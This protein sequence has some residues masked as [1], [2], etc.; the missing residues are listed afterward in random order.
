MGI[1]TP[2]INNDDAMLF[3]DNQRI[4]HYYKSRLCS[5]AL[6]QFIWDWGDIETT[7]RLFFEKKLLFEGKACLIKPEGS[8]MWLSLGYDSDGT[9]DV[10]GYPTKIRG[11]GYNSANIEGT[12]WMV[13]YDNATKQSL[14][15]GI[16]LYARLLWE[17]HMTYRSNLKHQNIPYMVTGTKNQELSFRDFFM[18]KFAFQPYFLF[19]RKEDVE[20]F[21]VEKTDVP[22]LGKEMLECLKVIWSEA[23]SQLG[24]CPSGSIDKK[25]RLITDEVAFDKEE[26][27]IARNTRELMRKEFCVKFNKKFGTNISV[28]MATID[29]SLPMDMAMEE[30]DRQSNQDTNAEPGEEV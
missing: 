24:I 14:M 18:K 30:L 8:D 23:I 28:H 22:Y 26:Y 5:L 29:T 19:K 25:E 6:S 12:D 3:I 16:D 27:I 11:V 15:E 20:A 1:M 17:Q 10:Y 2:P 21:K 13:L 9:L 7:D 4:F